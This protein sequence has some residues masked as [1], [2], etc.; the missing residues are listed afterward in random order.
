MDINLKHFH[1]LITFST[2][3]CICF[4]LISSVHIHHRLKDLDRLSEDKRAIFTT[5][6]SIGYGSD[7]DMGDHTPHWNERLIASLINLKIGLERSWAIPP[8]SMSLQKSG[9]AQLGS[10][11]PWFSGWDLTEHPVNLSMVLNQ[12]KKGY[13]LMLCATW[14]VACKEGMRMLISARY[15][16]EIEDIQVL[17][18]FSEDINLSHLTTWLN[19]QIPPQVTDRLRNLNQ[20]SKRKIKKKRKA[21]SHTRSKSKEHLTQVS[22]TP[23]L[24][25]WRNLLVFQDRYLAIAKRLGAYKEEETQ[26]EQQLDLPRVVVFDRQGIVVDIIHQEGYDFLDR[27]KLSLN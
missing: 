12:N 26:T 11:M 3:L 24:S 19:E 25:P 18:A 1:H 16:L 7:V 22:S 8:R 6:P 9:E 10:P 27:V 4:V 17:L 20:K 14:C 21:N 15:Q 5:V 13:I 2:R 23:M